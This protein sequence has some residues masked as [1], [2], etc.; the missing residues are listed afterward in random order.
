MG[1]W[2][3]KSYENDDAADAVDAGL[4]R[5][6]GD[7]Y[8]SLMDDR[9]PLTFDQA[10]EQLAD[11]AT[12]D[13]AI[14][15]L[16]QDV[17]PD[18]DDSDAWGEVERLAFAGVVVRHAEFGVPIPAAWRDRA[19]EWLRGERIDWDEAAARRVRREREIALLERLKDV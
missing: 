10:Q 2:G 13:A 12:L 6:H 18:L 1:R 7:T 5:V 15:A 8:E 4:D 3:V 16:R 17:G 11:P 14:E 19:I 9:S